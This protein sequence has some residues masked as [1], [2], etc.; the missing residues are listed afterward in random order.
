MTSLQVILWQEELEKLI[1]DVKLLDLEQYDLLGE[2]LDP[3][4][5][6]NEVLI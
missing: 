5:F 2:L 6:L 4:L 3:E 1:L